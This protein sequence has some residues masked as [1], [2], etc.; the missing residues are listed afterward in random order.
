MS[1]NE[2]GILFGYLLFLFAILGIVLLV[3]CDSGWSVMGWEVK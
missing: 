1:K 3:S 2:M